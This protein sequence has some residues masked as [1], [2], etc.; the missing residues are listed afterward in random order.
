MNNLH[1]LVT[2]AC[3]GVVVLLSAPALAQDAPLATQAAVPQS[4][5]IAMYGALVLHGTVAASDLRDYAMRNCDDLTAHDLVAVQQ[6]LQ[7]TG[8]YC[9]W[10][11]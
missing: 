3:C 8:V 2:V 7:R 4:E 1:R 9:D 6:W 10:P 5:S 11:E